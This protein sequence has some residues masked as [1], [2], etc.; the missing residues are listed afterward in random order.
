MSLKNKIEKNKY[1]RI[2]ITN[3][4]D[5]ELS[6]L[7]YNTYELYEIRYSL[8]LVDIL[9]RLYRFTD[10][11]LKVLLSDLTSELKETK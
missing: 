7:T 3:Y 10:S 8:V 6:L 5:N 1:N 4:S 11:Q 9:K 2:D